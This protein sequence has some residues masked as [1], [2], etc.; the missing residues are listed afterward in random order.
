MDVGA[1]TLDACVFRLNQNANTGDLYAFMAAQVRP[2]GVESFHWFLAEGK[3]E[4]EFVEQCNRMLWAVIWGTKRDRDPRAQCWKPGN[5]VPVF[6]AGGGAANR[7]H[8]DTIES[9]DP[10]LTQRV[11][12]DGIRLLELPVPTAIELPEPLEDFGRMAV[13]WGLSYPPTDIGR[14]QAMRDI[15]DIPPPAVVDP[16]NRFISKDHV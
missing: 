13:A 11:G 2:L 7:L 14:I 10:W 3:T 6:F 1:L 16:S 5:D 15:E 4:P 12:N 9:L 8:R